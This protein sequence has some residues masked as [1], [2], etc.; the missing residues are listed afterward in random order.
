M[1][2]ILGAPAGRYVTPAI[3][4]AL[5]VIYLTIAV[6]LP[7]DSA[8]MPLLVGL[9]LLVMLPIDLLSLTETRTGRFLRA[10]VNPVAGEPPEDF[11]PARTQLPAL[12]S[13][14]AFGAAMFL[15]GIAAAVPLYMFA[16]LRFLGRKSRQVALLT[17]LASGLGNY[18]LFEW[19]LGVELYPGVFLS[20]Y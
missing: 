2:T 20:P 3:L 17:A 6:S 11:G 12:G 10:R 18:L 13:V 16:S 7:R 15:L 5:V 8:M 4:L 19:G 14:V 9:V 1:K